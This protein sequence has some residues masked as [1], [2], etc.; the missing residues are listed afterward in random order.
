VAI[1][2]IE[3]EKAVGPHNVID[4]GEVDIAKILV[5]KVNYT[6]AFLTCHFH[7]RYDAYVVF[8]QYPRHVFIAVIH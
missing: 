3:I 1:I 2:I 8:K 6:E 4:S 5:E 7:H